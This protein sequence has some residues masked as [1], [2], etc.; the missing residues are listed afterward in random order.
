MRSVNADKGHGAALRHLPGFLALVIGASTILSSAGCRSRYDHRNDRV[1]YPDARGGTYY[2]P[3]YPVG[4]RQPYARESRQ[5]FGAR[6]RR[7][8][9][10]PSRAGATFW[11]GDYLS[12][13]PSIR[14]DLLTQRAYFYKGNELAGVSPVSTGR[15]GYETPT[16]SFRITQKSPAHRSNLYGDYVDANGNIVLPNVDIRRDKAPPAAP[17]RGASMPNFLRFNDAVGMHGGHLPGYP[18]SSGCVRLPDEMARHFFE[19]APTGTPVVVVR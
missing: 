1:L 11:N 12:G 10:T 16:G 8:K 17:F 7:E 18:A 19:H 2:P 13:A 4:P 5:R 3:G 6:E 14:I 9:R 15:P